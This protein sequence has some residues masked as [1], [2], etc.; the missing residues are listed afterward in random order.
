MKKHGKY[1]ETT[2]FPGKTHLEVSVYYQKGGINYFTNNYD[3]RGFY[4]SVTPVKKEGG[5]ITT[6][7]FTGLKQ[8]I[9]TVSRYSEKQHILAIEQSKAL[10]QKL[11]EKLRATQKSA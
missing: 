10:E 8:L 9:F 4:I 11:I 1:I 3:E 2:E 7:L 5:I 6:T